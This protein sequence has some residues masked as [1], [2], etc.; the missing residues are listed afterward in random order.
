MPPDAKRL[1]SST[2]V[3]LGLLGVAHIIAAETP[4]VSLVADN[5][6]VENIAPYGAQVRW[7]TNLPSDSKV[8]FATTTGSIPLESVRRCDE[9]GFVTDH[10]VNL[11]DL[12]PETKYYYEVRSASGT[13][14]EVDRAGFSFMTTATASNPLGGDT[15]SSTNE[16]ASTTTEGTGTDTTPPK[17]PG[18]VS[19]QV[20]S[21]NEISLSWS[22]S[23][24]NVGVAG[25]KVYRNGTFIAHTS[26]SLSYGDTGLAPNTE[27]RYK[28]AAYDAAGNFAWSD[29]IGTKTLMEE[30][31]SEISTTTQ[32]NKVVPA[33][34]TIT[35][36]NLRAEN[37]MG[38]GTQIKW[39]TSV[40]ANSKIIFGATPESMTR[41]S[42]SYCDKSGFVYEHCVNLTNLVPET[43]YHYRVR[44]EAGSGL[45][46]Y[47]EGKFS[48]ATQKKFFATTTRE[49]TA[50]EIASTATHAPLPD[51]KPRAYLG[52]D[53]E[54][55][56]IADGGT[57]RGLVRIRVSVENALSVALYLKAKDGTE[58]KRLGEATHASDNKNLWGFVFDSRSIGNG[59]YRLFSRIMNDADEYGGDS[60]GIRIENDGETP[61]SPATPPR[62]RAPSRI[63][64]TVTTPAQTHNEENR[65]EARGLREK[66]DKKP[67]DDSQNEIVSTT[68]IEV[69]PNVFVEQEILWTL[70][71]PVERRVYL[72]P[73]GPFAHDDDG[74]G[75]NN[76]D[77]ET[78]FKTNPAETDTDGDGMS[79]TSELLA[80]TSPLSTETAPIVY[81]NPKEAP[82][83]AAKSTGNAAAREI[84]TVESVAVQ[85]TI[86]TPEGE[87]K[88]TEIVLAGRGLPN[89]FVTLY[90]FST[91]IIVTIKTDQDGNW[92]YVLDKEIE[93]GSHEVYV[94]MTDAQGAIVVKSDPIPFVKE[95]QAVSL[96][97]DIEL[98]ADTSQGEASFWDTQT[99]TLLLLGLLAIF[100]VSLISFGLARKGDALENAPPLS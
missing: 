66:S 28:V 34:T 10:C 84:F 17:Q 19:A 29:E 44:S 90:I 20:I 83:T 45:F 69:V 92:K 33:T 54:Q 38:Y 13:G 5:I 52:L 12:A 93:D 96:A 98:A 50:D 23:G 57:L 80:G 46:A 62:E 55:G 76:Y 74:D 16:T 3:I 86:E 24:D 39:V 68:K 51:E 15:S 72:D 82:P 42:L 53:T 43:L 48:S 30:S 35:I 1:L 87:K 73:E 27:Y 70:P 8:L 22:V 18:N 71:P 67:V 95:A 99:I 94:A 81:E 89:S 56:K 4:T 65:R 7:L 47:A 41:Q 36:S 60:V 6:R 75:I 78:I 85:T 37:T 14:Q 91:P 77:E 11:S 61:V 31:L 58:P 64:T 100:G 25:Y 63:E 40:P 88:V 21:K 97:A 79:D 2:L 9:G 49:G 59:E 32:E 26:A